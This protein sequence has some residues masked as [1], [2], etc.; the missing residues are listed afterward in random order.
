MYLSAGALPQVSHNPLCCVMKRSIIGWSA[1]YHV[2]CWVIKS[3]LKGH[4]YMNSPY[5]LST[6]RL[7]WFYTSIEVKLPISVSYKERV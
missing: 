1:P 6:C 2:M 5:A 7:L 3:L 4:Y